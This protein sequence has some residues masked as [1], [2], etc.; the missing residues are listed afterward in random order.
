MSG[1][2]PIRRIPGLD[3]A[4]GVAILCMASYHFSW[5]LEYFHYLEP[6]TTSSGLFWLYAR[7]IASS[8][9]FMAGA[10]LSLGHGRGINGQKFL[11]RF[12]VIVAAALGITIVTSIAMP[13]G[14]IYFGILHQMALASLLGLFVLRWPS[15]VL[16]LIGVVALAL[17]SFARNPLFDEPWLL[18]VGLS[19]TVPHSNDYVPLLPWIAPF[20][21]GMASTKLLINSRFLEKFQSEKP[22]HH[23][24]GRA[25]TYAGRHSLT[26]YLVHQPLLFGLVWC[27]A[28]VAPAPPPNMEKA[29][30]RSCETSCSAQ[31]T[32]A[33]CTRF[34]T[35]TLDLL[36]ADNLFEALQSGTID[37]KKDEGIARI[38]GACSMR[39]QQP[40]L[41]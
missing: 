7:L 13:Q 12:A 24:V 30:V 22:V 3:M 26:I 38:S 41:Q 25:L 40:D 37:I 1:A 32:E 2:D 28:Q 14:A 23:P 33:F 5:D 11:R 9:L 21:F 17:P 34:C 20:L 19:E 27:I 18:W 4:R 35:C 29:Y 36:Q 6:G 39:A 15:P 31:Q 8:F 16:I 10:S